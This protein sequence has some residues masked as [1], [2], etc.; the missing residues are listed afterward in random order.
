M[1]ANFD[2]I[3][4]NIGVVLCTSTTRPAGGSLFTGMQIFETD[5][6][7]T[8][9]YDG[10]AWRF[11]GNDA[12]DTAWTTYTPSLTNITGGGAT[13]AAY[14]FL[15][16][17]TIALRGSV[18]TG[19]TAT[20][21]GIVGVSVPFTFPIQTQPLSV[22]QGRTVM[23]GVASSGTGDIEMSTSAGANFAAGASLSALRWAGV[24]EVV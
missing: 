15:G 11:V 2:K 18:A 6:K 7:K 17:K 19:A 12:L 9:I 10:A 16:A 5:T 14:K 22:N 21:A 4:L 23:G 3:D 13:I 24:I 1:N 20:A 8:Y